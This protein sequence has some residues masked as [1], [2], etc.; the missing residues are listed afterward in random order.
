MTAVNFLVWLYSAV[1]G[2]ENS[3][4]YHFF[5]DLVSV[6]YQFPRRLVYVFFSTETMVSNLYESAIIGRKAG[7]TASSYW[8]H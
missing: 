3:G 1:I 4:R 6:Q 8:Y 5:G 7:I 2:D